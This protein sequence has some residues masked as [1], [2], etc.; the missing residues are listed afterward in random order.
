MK[1]SKMRGGRLQDGV[2]IEDGIVCREKE[3]EALDNVS[4]GEW[5]WAANVRGGRML[6][7]VMRAARSK[8][9]VVCMGV[10]LGNP[11]ACW[12]EQTGTARHQRQEIM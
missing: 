8:R 2:S 7:E 12:Q 11:A 10:A 3:R 6:N 5:G 1:K 4:K 9:G